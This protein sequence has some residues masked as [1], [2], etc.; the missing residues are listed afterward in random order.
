MRLYEEFQPMRLL[1]THKSTSRCVLNFG[2]VTK[3]HAM[4]LYDIETHA[5]CLYEFWFWRT[6][7]RQPLS[8]G[9]HL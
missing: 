7:K 1:F 8:H 9:C 5:M 4:R 6:V 3:T 2:R